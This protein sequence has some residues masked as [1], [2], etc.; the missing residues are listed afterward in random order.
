MCL[1]EQPR[2]RLTA[3]HVPSCRI[4]VSPLQKDGGK[5]FASSTAL[6]SAGAAQPLL[7]VPVLDSAGVSADLGDAGADTL[8]LSL[9]CHRASPPPGRRAPSAA[10]CRPAAGNRKLMKISC[11]ARS[12]LGE[13]RDAPCRTLQG[14]FAAVGGRMDASL[15]CACFAGTLSA[16]GPGTPCESQRLMNLT[17]A[18]GRAFFPAGRGHRAPDSGGDDGFGASRHSK[19]HH[20]GRACHSNT[21]AGT[22]A[23]ACSRLARTAPVR[24]NLTAMRGAAQGTAARGP[25]AGS[26]CSRGSP[27]RTTC[28]SSCT[29]RTASQRT[30]TSSTRS[31][32]CAPHARRGASASAVPPPAR[33]IAFH[34]A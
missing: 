33:R 31:R 25:G 4:A 22:A 3:R 8:F 15:R 13:S 19:H 20:A 6:I 12:R 14:L 29:S 28:G 11:P 17:S 26:S 10:T 24:R 27:R 9:C 5:P 2:R 34:R 7:R 32:G 23:A 30:F 21:S 16:N 18:A 1:C